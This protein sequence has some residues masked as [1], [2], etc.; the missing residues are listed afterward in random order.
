MRTT[1]MAASTSQI[2]DSLY[3]PTCGAGVARGAGQ[4]LRDTGSQQRQQFLFEPRIALEP[5]VVASTGV[6][7]WD[8]L[9]QPTS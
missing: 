9:W 6:R 8:N 2:I 5:Q 3:Q 1:A 7:Q 4:H